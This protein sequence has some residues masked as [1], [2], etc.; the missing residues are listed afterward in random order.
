[1]PTGSGLGAAV[2]DSLVEGVGKPFVRLAADAAPGTVGP[3]RIPV[4]P[5]RPKS[6]KEADLEALLG[7]SLAN[8]AL[9][10]DAPNDWKDAAGLGLG[11]AGIVPFG[12]GVRGAGAGIKAGL[13]ARDEAEAAVRLGP[14][15]LDETVQE[16]LEGAPEA[17]AAQNK[18]YSQE[19]AARA[20]GAMKAYYDNGG[21]TAGRNAA[22]G[23]LKGALPKIDWNGFTEFTPE[24]VDRMTRHVFE[25]T[26]LQFYE[27]VRLAAGLDRVVSGR[28]PQE[29]QR[30]LIE[31]VFG[32]ATADSLTRVEHRDLLRRLYDGGLKIWNI[33]RTVMASYDISAP[34]RQGLVSGSRHPVI[35]ARNFKPM[36]K[37]LG[38]EKFTDAI[39]EEIPTRANFQRYGV[40]KLN[41]QDMHGT[42]PLR[43]EQFPGSYVDSLP[44]IKNSGR[45]YTVFLNKMRVDTFDRLVDV[46][47][48]HGKNVDDPRFLKA[49]GE[50]INTS[51]GR[52]RI[53][54]AHGEDAAQFLNTFL[55]S[56]R[57][58][59]SR[60]QILNPNYYV[61]LYRQDPF[62]AGQAL[63]AAGQTLAAI[64][65]MAYLAN[66]IPGTDVGMNPLSADFGKVR[67]GNT[68]VDFAGGFQPLIVLYSRLY[69]KKSVSSSSGSEQDINGGFGTST[70]PDVVYRF[71]QSKMSPSMRLIWDRAAE[72]TYIGDPVT[73]KGQLWS[74]APL[75]LQGAANTYETEG[76][77]PAAAGAAA[78]GSIGFGVGS[79]PDKS[80][81]SRKTKKSEK[82]S[83]RQPGTSL[84]SSP[85][86]DKSK[87]AQP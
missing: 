66:N 21:G 57:L 72:R 18:V 69:K 28:A 26:D 73:V 54:G 31:R 35:F 53:P 86:I 80:P 85:G 3:A 33:P 13:K 60:F 44:G 9:H 17:I 65:S 46:A 20:Q 4:S 49:L 34:F 11:V 67:I 14:K 55:F 10:G 76:S 16:A 50:Y 30:L 37:A 8:L 6:A 83:W 45:A 24:T 68:R 41:I 5:K 78:L 87:W 47:G 15:T 52:G 51:T 36:L 25:E 75:N 38:S 70:R 59:A 29:S 62:V 48:N 40:A 81:T 74:M 56:P 63:R 82:S 79:Y 23:E 1:M 27:K 12:R 39:M 64:S 84:S 22:L 7:K 19:R 2:L 43:E 58:L 61:R 42:G 32:K 71:F 77:V